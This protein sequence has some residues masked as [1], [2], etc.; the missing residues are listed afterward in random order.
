MMNT[1]IRLAALVA[2]AATL[3]Q[4]PACTWVKPTISAENVRVAYD[5]NVSGCRDAGAISV[6]VTDKVAFYHRPALK[7]RDELETLA[8]NQAAGIPADTIKPT[9]E[10]RDGAQNFE[11]Y[12]CG[13]V[14][15]KQRDA[16]APGKDD[17][18]TF[19]VKDH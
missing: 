13:G 14:R 18:Q 16:S 1:P 6:S 11:A 7:V 2:V 4:L 17:V 5:G 19:P 9:D 8:R 10:P 15:M 12:V 3:G